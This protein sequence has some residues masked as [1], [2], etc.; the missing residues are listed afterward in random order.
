MFAS[1][2]FSQDKYWLFFSDKGPEAEF[3]AQHPERVLSPRALQKRAKLGIAVRKSDYPVSTT[4]LQAL[5]DAGLQTGKTSRWINAVTVTTDLDFR[6]LQRI[7]PQV[8]DM[9]PVGTFVHNSVLAD[10]AS[11]AS[12]YASPATNP[13]TSGTDTTS[14]TF[15]YGASAQ[16]IEMLNLDCLHDRGHTGDGVLMA[17]FD[18]GFFKVDTLAAFDSMWNANRV[19]GWYDFVNQ[20][21]G[22]FD[23]SSHG[24][25]VISTITANRPGVYVGTAPHVSVVMAR[26][27]NVFSE[28]HQ[29]EDN[30][31]MAVE[32]ADSLGADIIQSS[33]GYNTFDPGEG[34]YVYA[35]MN[36]DSAIVTRAA[37]MAAA[38]GILV[39][40]SAGNEG[41]GAWHYI[42]APCDADSILCTGAVDITGQR[43]GFSSVG[44]T[45]DGRIKPDVMAMGSLTSIIGTGGQVSIGSG[46]SFASP[47][48]AG[49]VACLMGAHPDRTNMDVIKAVKMS[50]DRF[51]NPDTAYG[52][53]IPDA[54]KADS[55]LTVMDSL[56]TQAEILNNFGAF[57]KVYPNP[58]EEA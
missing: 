1:S 18:A 40:N 55:I 54:C 41:N 33:L 26:T 22:V 13:D 3:Y 47:Q 24:L 6:S 17:V 8:V 39:V 4:Y 21:S 57:V 42:T 9:Q 34:D 11:D 25:G 27:E 15:S 31:L 14:T 12:A 48:M 28:K 50:G 32:W 30:W 35:D 36:G 5:K 19:M 16:Q 29:E 46:T 53:G 2:G 23:E 20:D 51:M 52:A 58:A 37:D 45:A 7:C 43:A 38:R 44:P 49:L 56:A 10:F